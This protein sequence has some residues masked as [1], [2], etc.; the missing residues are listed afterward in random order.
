MS[1]KTEPYILSNIEIVKLLI[2]KA[3]VLNE[4]TKLQAVSKP[5]FS[6]SIEDLINKF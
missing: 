4:L 3:E 6:V 5:E 1:F 2:D